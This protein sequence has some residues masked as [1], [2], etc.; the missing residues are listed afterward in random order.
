MI[1][2]KKTLSKHNESYCLLFEANLRLKNFK[3]KYREGNFKFYINKKSNE[4]SETMLQIINFKLHQI[5]SS[6][7]LECCHLFFE[8]LFFLLLY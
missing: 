5:K 8:K 3:I 4:K 1:S 2:P 6:L 7:T